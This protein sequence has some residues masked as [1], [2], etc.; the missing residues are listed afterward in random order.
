MCLGKPKKKSEL[1]TGY[2]FTK[3]S[4]PQLSLLPQEEA[5]TDE[6]I[7]FFPLTFDDMFNEDELRQIDKVNLEKKEVEKGKRY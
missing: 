6:K 7:K 4:T 3:D 2:D 1:S 5:K